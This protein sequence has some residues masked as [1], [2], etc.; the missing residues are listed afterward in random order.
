VARPADRTS[1]AGAHEHAFANPLGVRFHIGCFAAARGCA[2]EGPAVAEWSWFPPHTWQ[3]E[4][5]AACGAHLGWL[6]R[7]GG[8]RFHGLILDRLVEVDEGDG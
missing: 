8:H 6:F 7:D 5:C 1:V 3:V 4:R 2:P